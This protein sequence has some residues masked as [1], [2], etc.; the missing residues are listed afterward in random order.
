MPKRK[1]SVTVSPSRLQRARDL[2]PGLN[3]SEV[4]DR[5]LEALVER[6][7]ER[8]WLEAHGRAGPADLP[9]DVPVDLTQAPWEP[10]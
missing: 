4:V 1:V 3:L 6:E 2:S 8:R 9:E 5:A 7:L 10:D